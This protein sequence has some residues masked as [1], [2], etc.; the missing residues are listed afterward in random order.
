MDVVYSSNPINKGRRK[1]M[2]NGASN[3][4]AKSKSNMS[5]GIEKMRIRF[6]F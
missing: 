1:L 6:K 2:I 4:I 3:Q 5:P